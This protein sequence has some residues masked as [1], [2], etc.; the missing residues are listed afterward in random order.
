MRPEDLV[1]Q[2]VNGGGSAFMNR[3]NEKVLDKQQM[4]EREL[5]LQRQRDIQTEKS[6]EANLFKD[7]LISEIQPRKA[8]K[9]NDQNAVTYG[10]IQD[11]EKILENCA[12]MASL[13]GVE[14]QYQ[15]N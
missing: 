7:H 13:F 9:V 11:K 14:S 15:N 8:Q 2:I 3:R 12:K 4:K 10:F 5:F 1:P 6:F